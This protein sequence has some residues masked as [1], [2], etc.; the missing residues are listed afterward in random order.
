MNINLDKI[1]S[2]TDCLK[3]IKTQN[4]QV[5]GVLME[6]LK[7]FDEQDTQALISLFASF[8]FDFIKN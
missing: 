4:R 1:L 7:T 8:E 2:N 3:A 6:F 5:Y